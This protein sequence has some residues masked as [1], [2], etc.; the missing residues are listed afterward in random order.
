MARR[1]S[2]FENLRSKLEDQETGDVDVDITVVVEADG[3]AAEDIIDATEVA[4]TE[5]DADAVVEA[6]EAAEQE[7]EDMAE[8]A[9]VL[10]KHGLN[11]GMAALLKV[12]VP[13]DAYGIS[14][15]AYESL[16]ASGRNQDK[17]DR[18]AAAFEKADKSFWEGTKNFFAKIWQWIKDTLTKLWDVMGRMETR[19]IRTGEAL[20]KRTFNADR[21]KDK[22]AKVL[23]DAKT[24]FGAAKFA[25]AQKSVD[26]VTEGM[27]SIKTLTEKVKED[28]NDANS[29]D[30]END[31]ANIKKNIK[32]TASG[33]TLTGLGMKWKN[34]TGNDGKDADDITMEEENS[35]FL[36]TEDVEITQDML[37]AY[38]AK[39]G[40]MYTAALNLIKSARKLAAKKDS[41][42][43]NFKESKKL[44]EINAIGEDKNSDAVKNAKKLL[45]LKKAALSA[46]QK[47][48]SRCSKVSMKFCGIYVS[49]GSKILGATVSEGKDI[50]YEK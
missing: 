41:I 47:L 17:A 42:K 46:L 7:A 6:D 9:A 24:D 23:K 39:S 8:M 20:S 33:E 4:E 22:K 28:P 19:I 10:R 5:A 13:M 48:I 25:A 34:P 29:K 35:S 40:P 49:G 3:D 44:D 21:A 16:D 11:A 31:I 2:A 15:P 18:L 32:T 12:L 38:Q 43:T 1:R 36:D 45:S 27:E 26:K 37:T 50:D 14:M 30:I